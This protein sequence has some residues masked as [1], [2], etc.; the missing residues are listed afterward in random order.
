MMGKMDPNP[1]EFSFLALPCVQGQTR[2]TRW[3][4]QDPICSSRLIAWDF[5][6]PT[7]PLRRCLFKHIIGTAEIPKDRSFCGIKEDFLKYTLYF[8]AVFGSQ[9]KWREGTV[10]SHISPLSHVCRPHYQHPHHSGTF[11]TSLSARSVFKKLFI[12]SLISA[13]CLP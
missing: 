11:V 9:Q 7:H 6:P 1:A 12:S 5:F 4:I 13:L 10:I 8:W 2:C 3:R